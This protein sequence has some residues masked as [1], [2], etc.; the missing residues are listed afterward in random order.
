MHPFLFFFIL[1]HSLLSA[2]SPL[3]HQQLSQATVALENQDGELLGTAFLISSNGYAATNVHV[4]EE[5]PSHLFAHFQDGRRAPAFLFGEDPSCDLALIKIPSA[6]KEPFL[7]LSHSPRVRIGDPVA[8]CGFPDTGE[9]KVFREGKVVSLKGSFTSLTPGLTYIINQLKL[10]HGMSGGALINGRGELIAIHNA[11]KGEHLS[12]A[13][14]VEHLFSLTSR[15]RL[16]YQE[17]GELLPSL[18]DACF[19]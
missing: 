6:H 19:Q 8:T 14:P 4:T 18:R 9:G 17:S 15:H 13:I 10:S 3:H 1:V 5:H 2:L 12:L 7:P 11:K 16:S